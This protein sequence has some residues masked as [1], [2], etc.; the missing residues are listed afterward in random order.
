MDLTDEEIEWANTLR[1][2]IEADGELDSSRFSDFDVVQ[3]AL[4]SVEFNDYSDALRRARSLQQF[5]KKYDI[6]DSAKAGLRAIK[7]LMVLFPGH[8]LSFSFDPVGGRYVI[9]IDRAQL[10][11]SELELG[12]QGIRTLIKVW[13]YLAQAMTCDF[14]SIIRGWWFLVESK[15]FVPSK[16]G[17]VTQFRQIAVD[18]ALFYPAIFYKYCHYNTD[19]TYTLFVS[20]I[21]WFMPIPLRE[22]IITGCKPPM[23]ETLRDT[24]LQPSLEVSNV[25]F[26]DA[27]QQALH[28]R[29]NNDASFVLSEAQPVEFDEQ[30]V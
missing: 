22:K 24:F 16:H 10:R 1:E 4:V 7:D 19:S 13:Y 11:A 21:K 30:D 15:D 17:T 23:G 6:E 2:E 12:G 18:L 28:R 9:A 20:M 14:D 25:K 8:L 27:V 26:I 5:K 29:Y 3:I